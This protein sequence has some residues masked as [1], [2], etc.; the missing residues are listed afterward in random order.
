MKEVT[1]YTDGFC[2]PNPGRGGWAAILLYGSK[3]RELCGA[4]EDTTN[5]RME[6]TAAIKSLQALSEPCRVNLYTDSE[7]LRQGITEWLPNW[8]ARNWRTSGR[9]PVKNKDLWEELDHLSTR[10]EITWHWVKGHAGN[11]LNERCD[12]LAA[13]AS[14]VARPL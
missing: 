7:Y 13:Q 10:H 12:Y 2:E 8:K 1:I 14:R 9:Q 4:E 6:L 5:N 11:A 3:R